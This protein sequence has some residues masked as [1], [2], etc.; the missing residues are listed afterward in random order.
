MLRRRR[1]ED[2]R[3]HVGRAA[4]S[5]KVYVRRVKNYGAVLRTFPSENEVK[6]SEDVG[7]MG[8]VFG[9]RGRGGQPVVRNGDR[10][11]GAVD[12]TTREDGIIGFVLAVPTR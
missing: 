4:M 3:E 12:E 11:S 2:G 6:K 5:D 10:E 7:G 9:E 1:E 8:R